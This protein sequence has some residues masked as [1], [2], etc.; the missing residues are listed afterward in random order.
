MVDV[1]PESPRKNHQG[2]SVAGLLLLFGCGV[3]ALVYS[4]RN[5]SAPGAARRLVN[6]VPPTSANFSA[7]MNVYRKDCQSCHGA[8]GDGKGEKASELSIAPTDFTASPAVNQATDGELFWKI[9]EGRRPMPGFKDRLSELER[10]QVVDY[11]RT[12]AQK[13]AA[14]PP[15]RP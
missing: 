1:N 12:L 11:I 5:W 2:V 13:P 3:I 9:S 6:Q 10:W 14:R 15:E 4:A 8:N 7:G